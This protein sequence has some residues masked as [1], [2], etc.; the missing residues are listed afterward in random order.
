MA[1]ITSDSVCMRGIKELCTI[2]E[3]SVKSSCKYLVLLGRERH[4]SLDRIQ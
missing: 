4:F 1:S 2:L 3:L